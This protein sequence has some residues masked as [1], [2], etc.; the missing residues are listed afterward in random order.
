[1]SP[2]PPSDF[3][4]ISALAA[5]TT[6]LT[7][8]EKR[9]WLAPGAPGQGLV[10]P[11]QLVASEGRRDL[12]DTAARLE[13]GAPLGAHKADG[14]TSPVAAAVAAALAFF[15]SL[16]IPKYCLDLNHAMTRVGEGP[17]VFALVLFALAMALPVTIFSRQIS[18]RPSH[19]LWLVCLIGAV[20]VHVIV[21][22]LAAMGASNDALK[23]VGEPIARTGV[24]FPVILVLVLAFV[25][26]A[27]NGM[28]E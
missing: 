1:M 17:S 22:A 15:V 5:Y 28:E 21:A 25:T 19:P 24:L 16:Y 23:G 2:T 7:G 18:S 12:A 8:T 4:A 14:S 9:P 13:A 27:L 11:T 6:D 3:E 20:V 26:A 10:R